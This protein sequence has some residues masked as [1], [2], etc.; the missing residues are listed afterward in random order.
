MTETHTS[1]SGF[2]TWEAPV[3]FVNPKRQFGDLR[4][5]E[6]GD[7]RPSAAQRAWERR[8]ADDGW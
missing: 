7:D 5:V 8:S 1:G 4:D 6:E 2:N 3:G